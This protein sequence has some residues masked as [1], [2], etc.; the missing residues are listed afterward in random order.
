[1][2]GIIFLSIAIAGDLYI[3]YM[4]FKQKEKKFETK[5]Q[6][7][8]QKYFDSMKKLGIKKKQALEHYSE[9]T[10]FKRLIEINKELDRALSKFNL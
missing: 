4:F 2:I 10:T 1:M 9:I 5:F 8:R 3:V 6:L 7:E